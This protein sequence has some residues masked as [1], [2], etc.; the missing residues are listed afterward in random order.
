MS[1]HARLTKNE[2][3]VIRPLA[4]VIPIGVTRENS[5]K[6]PI[7]DSTGKAHKELPLFYTKPI[8]KAKN[9]DPL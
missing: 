4:S 8:F 7:K 3:I 5:S 1:H 6:Q 2:E 9:H